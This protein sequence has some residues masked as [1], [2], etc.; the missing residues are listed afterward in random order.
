MNKE[1][2]QLLL[3]NPTNVAIE[4]AESMIENTSSSWINDN[5]TDCVDTNKNETYGDSDSSCCS[6]NEH[7]VEK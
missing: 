6:K 2:G 4:F 5:H 3:E 7:V 1:E